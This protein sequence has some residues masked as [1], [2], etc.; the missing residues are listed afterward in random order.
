MDL[1][2]WDPEELTTVSSQQVYSLDDQGQYI[3][4]RTNHVKQ[5]YGLITYMKHIL[6]HTTLELSLLMT[7]FVPSH[8]MNGPTTPTQMRTYLIQ[9]LPNPHG[10]DLVPSG[11]VSSTRPTGYSP[12]AIELIGFKKGIKREIAA[13]PSLKDERYFDGV[14]RSLFIVSKSPKCNEVLDP[15]LLQLVN[16]SKR[17]SLKPNKLLCLLS[18]MLTFRLTWVRPLSEGT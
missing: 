11:P 6:G 17:S 10:S 12:A 14:K 4:L 8:Q 7:H 5:I 18:L 9:N 13:Y 2:S 15:P 3:H 16:L 1:L